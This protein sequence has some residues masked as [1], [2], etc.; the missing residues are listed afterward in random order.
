MRGI[1]SGKTRSLT[2]VADVSFQLEQ[3][4]TLGL[5]GESGCGK[6]T[7]G[8]MLTGLIPP[9][10]GE[11]LF[12]GEK[13]SLKHHAG[14]VQMVFQ[15]PF[16]SLDPRWSIGASIAEPMRRTGLA[17]EIVREKTEMMLRQ[18]GLDPSFASRRPHSFSGGQRQRAAIAR[19][20]IAEPDVLVC[21]EAVSA[22]DASVQAQVLNLLKDMQ[23]M[24]RTSYVF[25]SHS[26]P[27]VA[28]M[29]DRIAVMYMGRFFELG[30]RDAVLSRPAH[31]YTKSLQAAAF[32]R[33]AG[34]LVPGEPPDPFDPPSGCPFHPR[35]PECRPICRERLPEA[36]D[37]GGSVPHLV[38][39]HLYG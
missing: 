28:F 12:H 25:I 31:P 13:L 30:E 8:R 35:C 7:L 19:A 21:D 9:T 2:A 38:R 11:I 27:A 18:V 39:C 6:S 15:N 22:L 34:T 33:S 1:L 16:S 14:R 32:G 4:E 29:S 5:V 20:L 36:A 3:G 37:I 10:S 24:R 17:A 23:E 26:F